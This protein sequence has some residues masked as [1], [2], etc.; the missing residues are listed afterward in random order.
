[1]KC[2]LLIFL[3]LLQAQ[4]VINISNGCGCGVDRTKDRSYFTDS[5]ILFDSDRPEEFCSLREDPGDI[6]SHG[7]DL[8]MIKVPTGLYQLGTDEVMIEID[9]EG[10]MRI[11]QVESFYLDKY[12]VSNRDFLQFVKKTNYKTEAETF[13]DTFVFTLFLNNTVKEDL[14]DFRVMQAPWWYKVTGASWEHPHGSDSDLK[15]KFI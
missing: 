13:G 3:F 15:G 6:C 8:N 1:M 4:N 11:V 9:R 2:N 12:E 7:T 14:K 10:P 5:S